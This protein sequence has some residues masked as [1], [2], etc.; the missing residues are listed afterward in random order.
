MISGMVTL[1][2]VVVGEAPR[3]SAARLSDWSK[4][5]SVAVTVMMTKGMPKV[6]WARMMPT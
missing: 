2:K 3:L 4:P 6:A 5:T 1:K